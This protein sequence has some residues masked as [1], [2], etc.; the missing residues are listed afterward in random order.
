MRSEKKDVGEVNLDSN[1]KKTF[2]VESIFSKTF[3]Q[4]LSWY[5]GKDY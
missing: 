5:H 3:I 1:K 4:I 2:Y